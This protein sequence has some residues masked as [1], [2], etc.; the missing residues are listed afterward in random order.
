MLSNNLKGAKMV[1]ED[2]RTD[3]AVEERF[4]SPPLHTKTLLQIIL[5]S[6]GQLLY[7]DM[8]FIELFIFLWAWF[9]CNWTLFMGLM[10]IFMTSKFEQ[11]FVCWWLSLLMP[12]FILVM[13]F[14]KEP[15]ISSLIVS[16]I[17]CDNIYNQ[18][19]FSIYCNYAN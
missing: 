3:N 15:N 4:L 10:L 1:E 16:I 14:I 6:R 13:G 2:I 7:K 5:T 11:Y 19:L 9:F 8:N 12:F 17:F 18:L